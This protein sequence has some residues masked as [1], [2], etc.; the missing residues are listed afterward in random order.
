MDRFREDEKMIRE[1]NISF[2]LSDKFNDL[3]QISYYYEQ[4]EHT[5]E[6]AA[7]MMK[8]EI[9]ISYEYIYRTFESCK[10]SISGI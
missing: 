3:Y 7:K 8:N 1:W 5:R 6:I 4:A 10:N 9:I 2:V